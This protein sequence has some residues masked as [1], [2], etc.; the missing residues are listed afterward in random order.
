MLDSNILNSLRHNMGQTIMAALDDNDVMEIMLNGDS[1]LWVDTFSRGQY[2]TGKVDP[3]KAKGIISMVASLLGTT[4]TKDSPIVEG[5][6]PLDGSRFEGLFPPVVENPVFTIRKKALKVFTLDDYVDN[7]IMSE[8]ARDH[9]HQAVDS[10][11][12]ILVVGGTGSG[13]TTLCNA[14]LAE[15]STRCPD[16]RLIII[17]DTAELQCK[18]KNKVILRTAPTTTMQHLLKATMRLRPDRIIVGEVRGGEALD[19]LKAWNTG[20]PG[21]LCTVHAND[22]KGGLIR[23]EQ[24]IAEVSKSPM[25]VLIKEAINLVIFIKKTPQGRKVKEV[26]KVTNIADGNYNL[27]YII[28]DN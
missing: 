16:D 7:N 10:K 22:S 12:N 2:C 17:E 8:K 25:Q 21:G 14:V 18:C 24:L 27:E 1:T 15:I 23:I 19:L 3:I 20:H 26:A 28:K 4:V 5:E 6:L 11:Q 9:I 13:K